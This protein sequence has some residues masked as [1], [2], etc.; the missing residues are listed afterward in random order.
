[1]MLKEIIGILLIMSCLLLPIYADASTQSVSVAVNPT[2]GYEVSANGTIIN[3]SNVPVKFY[4]QNGT[5][6]VVE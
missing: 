3:L 4:N 6:Y 5:I 2:V 1:M